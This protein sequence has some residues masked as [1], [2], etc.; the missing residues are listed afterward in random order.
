MNK[1]AITLSINF[2]VII[3]ISL[4]VLGF[5][6]KFIYDIFHGAE[7]IKD[8]TLEDIDA[9][10][11]QL[12]CE[13]DELVCLG[14]DR[15]T[16]KH[17]DLGVFGLKIINMRDIAQV[18]FYIIVTSGDAFDKDGIL[19]SNLNVDCVPTCGLPGRMETIKKYEEKEIGLGMKVENNAASGTYIFDLAVC[20]DEPSSPDDTTGKCTTPPDLY[21]FDKIYVNVP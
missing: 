10:I 19:M 7:E 17:G 20:Y 21:Y 9:Q 3:I 12:L 1:K 6:I 15:K 11:G 8:I 5:G 13:G 14:I 4:V 16:I 2:L 18:D